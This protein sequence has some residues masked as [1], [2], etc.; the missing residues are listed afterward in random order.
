MKTASFS[1]LVATIL[2]APRAAS[3][4]E[5]HD[6][7]QRGDVAKIRSILKEDPKAIN[8]KQQNGYSPLHVAINRSRDDLVLELLKHKPDANIQDNQGY[9]PLHWA[10]MRYRRGVIQPLLDG[11]ASIDL[12]LHERQPR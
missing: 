3:A 8:S 12:F 6:A 1:V 11:G 2:I 7:V 10:V 5:I 4:G 9:T